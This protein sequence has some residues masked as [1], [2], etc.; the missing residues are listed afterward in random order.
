MPQP[1]RHRSIF[2][3]TR[4]FR[5]TDTFSEEINALAD[6]ARKH[7][8]NVIRDAVVKYIRFYDQNPDALDVTP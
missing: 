7:P 4:S 8:S 2:T 3:I 6:R 1:R 5:V